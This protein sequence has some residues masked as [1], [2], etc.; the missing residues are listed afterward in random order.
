VDHQ[1]VHVSVRCSLLIR[2]PAIIFVFFTLLA[3]LP[4]LFVHESKALRYVGNKMWFSFSS[5]RRLATQRCR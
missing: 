3:T 1:C 4:L 2:K 5:V